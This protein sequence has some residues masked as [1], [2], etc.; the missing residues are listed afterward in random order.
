MP[1][2]SILHARSELTHGGKSN[3]PIVLST[4]IRLARNLRDIPFPGWAKPAQRQQVMEQCLEACSHLPVMKDATVL[5]VKDLTE[6]E[7]RILVERHLISREL[8]EGGEGCAVVIS[9]DQSCAIMI[10]E[11]DHLRMQMMRSG[12][13]F[14]RVWKSLDGV[15]SQMEEHLNFAFSGDLGYLTA[16]PTNLGTGMR[17]SAMMHLPALVIVNSMEKVI[18]A[19]NQLGMVVR[20][21]FGEGSNASGSIFQISNQQTLGESEEEIIRRLISVLDSIIEQEMN[22]REKLIEKQPVK[23]A[24]RIGRSFGVLSQAHTMTSEEAMNLLSLLRLAVDLK[25]LPEESRVDIDRLFIEVQPGHIQF[26]HVEDREPEQRD[27]VRSDLLRMEMARLPQV[28]FSAIRDNL[29]R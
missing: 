26:S 14:K 22:A 19:V 5:Q 24:D 28:D 9:K 4:R 6:L 8:S 13:F 1:I 16:C 25:A 18:R 12:F 20:G 10:N 15:D 7:R 3:C 17:A 21:L 29:K 11:E 23:L 2:E 27:A